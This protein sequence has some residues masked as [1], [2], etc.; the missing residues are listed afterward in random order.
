MI[1]NGKI[2]GLITF[3]SR[4]SH[5]VIKNTPSVTMVTMAKT[6]PIRFL[7]SIDIFITCLLY[8]ALRVNGK[9]THER[10][11]LLLLNQDIA[12]IAIE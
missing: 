1:T 11:H 7:R 8:V 3:T 6:N 4:Q 10:F 12:P 2:I 9:S 5:G